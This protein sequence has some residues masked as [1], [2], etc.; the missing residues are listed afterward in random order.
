MKDT[1]D[2][3]KQRADRSYLYYS[4]PLPVS[5]Q[6]VGWKMTT[7]LLL[8]HLVTPDL[9]GAWQPYFAWWPVQVDAYSVAEIKD[10]CMSY[11]Q[12][13]WVERRWFVFTDEEGEVHQFWRYR[14][15]P[16]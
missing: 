5:N 7:L 11:P 15:A 16:L 9:S 3:Y 6:D 1:I 14:I 8:F 4:E 12:M 2:K 13:G 10:G